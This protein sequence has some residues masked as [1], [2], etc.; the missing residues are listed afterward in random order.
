VRIGTAGWNVPAALGDG[1]PKAGSHLERYATRLNCVEIN[2]SFYRPHQKKTYEGW[3]RSTP[4]TFRFAVKLPQSIS[5]TEDLRFKPEDLDRFASEAGGLGAKLGV[6]LVQ[7]P[8][9]LAFD[10]PAAAKLFD[11]LRRYFRHP[12]ACEPRHASWFT[13]DVGQWMAERQIARVA[14]DPARVDGAGEPGGWRGFFYIRLHGSPDVYYSSYDE[15]A[16]ASLASRTELLV[17][18]APV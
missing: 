5:H 9:R 18:E 17:P 11:A 7:F 8:P 3:A 1:F 15:D 12:V 10:Q 4:P 14:A 6:L 16:L 2:S 13:S